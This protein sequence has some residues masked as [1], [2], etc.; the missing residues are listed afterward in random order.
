MRAKRQWV[1]VVV[2]AVAPWTWFAIRNLAAVFDLVATGLPA[3]SVLAA[4]SLA[5]YAALRR[6]R[7]PV[8]G[9]VSCLVAGAVAVVGPWRALPLP[10]PVRGIRIVAANVN[11][12]NPTI[13]R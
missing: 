6:R 1:A 12:K 10:P 9:V 5:G 13:E 8:V 11:S 2:A 7:L 4:L 3:L